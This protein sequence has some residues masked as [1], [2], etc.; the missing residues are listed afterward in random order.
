[1]SKPVVF[2][3][4][5]VAL[6]PNGH[7]PMLMAVTSETLWHGLTQS[8]ATYIPLLVPEARAHCLTCSHTMIVADE[9]V[10]LT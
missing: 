1:M 2:D 7:G 8:S 9:R 3:Q 4:D 6:C 5:E 10:Y